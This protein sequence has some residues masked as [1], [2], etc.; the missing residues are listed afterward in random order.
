MY[1]YNLLLNNHA[2]LQVERI[3]KRI[4]NRAG[5]C[6]RRCLTKLNSSLFR[7]QHL[8][9]VGV[10]GGEGVTPKNDGGAR[11]TLRG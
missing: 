2:A 11:R 1:S 6:G 5:S 7:V 4:F 3:Y 9:G 10:G 8:T